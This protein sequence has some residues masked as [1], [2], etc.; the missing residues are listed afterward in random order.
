MPEHDNEVESIVNDLRQSVIRDPKAA[1]HYFISLLETEWH[2]VTKIL[3]LVG[4][5]A[6]W[7]L[8]HLV[9]TVSRLQNDDRLIPQLITWAQRETDEFA[10]RAIAAAIRS[11]VPGNSMGT[12]QNGRSS[13][14]LVA[15]RYVSER[16]C[17]RVRNALAEP[18][19]AVDRIQ[20][21]LR[22]IGDLE[23]QANLLTAVGALRD[24]LRVVGRVVEF[25]STDEYVTSKQVNICAWIEG[26]NQRYSAQISPVSLNIEADDETRASVVIASEFLL[27]TIF[28][29]TWNNARQAAGDNCQII[30]RAWTYNGQIQMIM[31]DGG[32][33]FPSNSTE[34]VFVSP[35]STKEGN[36]G[37]GLLEIADAID[38]LGGTAGLSAVDGKFHML[39]QLPRQNQ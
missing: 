19:T 3:S 30:I 13:E 6:D 11:V 38:K 9:A 37:R 1:R 33:G 36:R 27:D 21:S 35:F 7:R 12:D 20:R 22:G 18:L 14:I 23:L 25:D 10:K 34:D 15:Y 16:L 32:A 17:H 39:I 2:T 29:N 8:R 31:L 26:M 4:E 24:K 5:P 28:W